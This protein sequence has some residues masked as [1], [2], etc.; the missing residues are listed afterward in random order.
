MLVKMFMEFIGIMGTLIVCL[1]ILPQCIKTYRTKSAKDLSTAYLSILMVGLI[2]LTFYSVYR[3]VPVFV[4]GNI[5]SM[6]SVAVLIILKRR[7][8]RNNVYVFNREIVHH[9][10]RRK[11]HVSDDN[12]FT[13]Y[14]ESREYVQKS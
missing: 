10:E 8:Y 14:G 5:L 7:Y 1:S 11:N 6:V 2:L 4:Y 3:D 13:G 12:A 9:K